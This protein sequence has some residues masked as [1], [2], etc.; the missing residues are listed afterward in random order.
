VNL[1]SKQFGTNPAFELGTKLSSA[2]YSIDPERSGR[3]N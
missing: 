3:V 1:Y 2:D